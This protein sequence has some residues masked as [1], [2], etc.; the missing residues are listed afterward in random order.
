ML[1]PAQ[2]GARVVRVPKRAVADATDVLVALAVGAPVRLRVSITPSLAAGRVSQARVT[3][4]DLRIAGLHL[5][6]V[7][8]RAQQLRIVPRWPPRVRAE[9]IGVRVRVEQDALDQWT[10]SKALPVRLA[11]R[12]G[13]I[14]ARAGIAGLRLGELDVA[15]DLERGRLRLT[16]RRMSM[17]GAAFGVATAMPAV[18]LPLPPLPRHAT[19][20][21]VEPTV[22]A[23]DLSFGLA[24]LHEPLTAERLRLAVRSVR[25]HS[26]RS[27]NTTTGPGVPAPSRRR[28]RTSTVARCN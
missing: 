27:P 2:A 4:P 1:T 23:I 10:H 6:V 7:D 21:A 14:S 15:V 19:L 24:Y 28:P 13:I 5:A 20:L 22:G 25:S 17:L 9:R 8:V 12:A 26:A 11:L 16:P 3:I 18:T